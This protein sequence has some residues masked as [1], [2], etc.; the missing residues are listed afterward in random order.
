MG[1]SPADDIRRSFIHEVGQPMM[2]SGRPY[3]TG[4]LFNENR[5]DGAS[6]RRTRSRS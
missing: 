2:K 1:D 5:L 6:L 4:W 3:S